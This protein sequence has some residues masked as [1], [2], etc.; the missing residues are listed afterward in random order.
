MSIAEALSERLLELMK[1]KN[2][3]AYRLSALTGVS[4]TTI[5]D[6]K[7]CR[8][9]AVNLR[10]IYELCQGLGVDLTEFFNSPLFSNENV[11]D[12]IYRKRVF[13]RPD[14]KIIRHIER[15]RN[16]PRPKWLSIYSVD[17]HPPGSL[18]RYCY[19]ALNAGAL[20]LSFLAF[21]SKMQVPYEYLRSQTLASKF[22][23]STL[24]QRR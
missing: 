19:S 17:L 18:L 11:S 23:H 21:L 2:L 5:G 7:K 12:W 8:N 13:F 9:T 22:A 4:Q 1:S 10:I 24:T 6:I 15:K 14:K 16:I 3:T 20:K